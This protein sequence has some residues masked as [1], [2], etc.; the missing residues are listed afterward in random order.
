M[1][2]K[3]LIAEDDRE[4][5][6][7]VRMHL[8][9][10]GYT[11]VE[12]ENGQAA[13]DLFHP[14][15]FHLV[16]LDLMMPVKGGLETL[17]EIREQSEVPVILLTAKGKDE[18][19][20]VGFGLGA[21][22]YLVKPFSMVELLSRV[23]AQLR[24]YTK[25]TAYAPTQSSILNNGSLRLDQKRFECKKNDEVIKLNPMEMKLLTFF[26]ENIGTTFTKKQLFENVWGEPFF[27]DNNTVMVHINFLRNKIEDDTKNPMY[28]RTIHGIGYRME[29]HRD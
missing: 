26:M 19:K 12:A 11:V 10:D 25:Y 17:Q 3:I 23:K 2:M 4:I 16:L 8:E 14:N 20:V 13:I 1:E 22:D 24:R 29:S 5:R 18:D 27:G 6:E 9:T 7:L 28:I 15:S 21:D